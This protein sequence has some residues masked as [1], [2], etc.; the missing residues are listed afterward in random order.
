MAAD[1]DLSPATAVRLRSLRLRVT[2]LIALLA[3]VGVSV[4]TV[5]VIRL[6]RQLRDEQIDT[7]LLRLSDEVGRQVSFAEGFLEPDDPSLDRVVLAVN[8]S[9][10][11]R[12]FQVQQD[13]FGFPDPTDEEL[14]DLMD[15]TFFEADVDSQRFL[16]AETVAA[17]ENEAVAERVDYDALIDDG[18][19]TIDE[20]EF[21]DEEDR[22][23][24][25]DGTEFFLDDLVA[26]MIEDPP[27]DLFDE[28]YRRYVIE[29]AD[30]AEVELEFETVFLGEDDAELTRTDIVNLTEDIT[31][32][33]RTVIRTTADA[34]DDSSQ[35]VVRAT[36]LRD[37]PEVRGA[38]IAVLDPT[39]FED[40]HATLRNQ[41]ILVAL[42]VVA[43]SVVAAW[44]VAGRTTRPTGRALAQQ[45]RFLADAAHELR[46]P[47]AAIRLTAEAADADSAE[48]SLRRVGELAADA[49]TLTDDLL[50]LARMD[51]DRMQLDRQRVR[52][53]LLVESIVAAIPGAE[54]AV[55]VR[56][57]DEV[58]APV[59]PSLVERAI[60]NLVRNAM[61]HGDARPGNTAELTVSTSQA[62][63]KVHMRDQGPGLDPDVADELF[64]RF[65]SRIGSSG[66]GLGL[67]LAR[68]IA[69]AHG[70]DLTIEPTDG[71]GATFELTL[72]LSD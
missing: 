59:D 17:V 2:A 16:L 35:R 47:I 46:T 71:P 25:F 68:W 28:A 11:I 36:P 24:T 51:A 39:E 48:A 20:F 32:N 1:V 62:S 50:T 21:L 40:A 42:A 53:D 72:P 5:A 19:V 58:I 9:F 37:G 12:E 52:I 23:D 29:E 49:S 15:A 14:R 65:R 69:R 7:E 26:S 61:V 56:A 60:G 57:P 18:F 8:P 41:V 31:E 10:S 54:D 33:G 30:E 22:T 34:T 44:F 27:E 70:G 64:E 3:T 6:D 55:D 13:L 67:P 38:V 63:V 43:A 4:F 45:E 66:H